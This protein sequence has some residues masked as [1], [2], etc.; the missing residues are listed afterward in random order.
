M[1]DGSPESRE[2]RSR[3]RAEA[4]ARPRRSSGAWRTEPL[5]YRARAWAI[6]EH[7]H[8]LLYRMWPNSLLRNRNARIDI[9]QAWRTAGAAQR[10]WQRWVLGSWS[11]SFVPTV[12]SLRR[13]PV[14][15][16]SSPPACATAAP[17]PQSGRHCRPSRSSSPRVQRRRVIGQTPQHPVAGLPTRR[18]HDHVGWPGSSSDTT[19]D[20]A[21][22]FEPRRGIR[23]PRPGRAG[24]TAALNGP[25]HTARVTSPVFSDANNAFDRDALG[26]LVAHF[27]DR[28]LAA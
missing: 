13:L 12:R 17:S 15:G 21:R 11:G 16:W 7:Y 18:L 19:P 1:A 22:S 5:M 2:T 6:R 24:K 4:R 23:A 27:A 14:A 20:I 26:Q 8:R 10:S 3:S 28:R 25:S 9:P